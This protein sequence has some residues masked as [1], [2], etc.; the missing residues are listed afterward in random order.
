MKQFRSLTRAVKRGH[1]R[2]FLNGLT[3]HID[4][5][6]RTSRSKK[7]TVYLQSIDLNRFNGDGQV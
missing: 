3:N 5:Y 1:V 2:G 6:R 7:H 4:M